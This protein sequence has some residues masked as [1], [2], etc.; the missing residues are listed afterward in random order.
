MKHGMEQR[1]RQ[2]LKAGGAIAIWTLPIGAAL[3]NS[4]STR[5]AYNEQTGTMSISPDPY[6]NGGS[7]GE[8]ETFNTASGKSMNKDLSHANGKPFRHDQISVQSAQMPVQSAQMPEYTFNGR[9]ITESCWNSINAN[10]RL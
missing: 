6:I 7:L 9:E 1:R 3:A 2:L 8:T 5:C 10:L 4:S